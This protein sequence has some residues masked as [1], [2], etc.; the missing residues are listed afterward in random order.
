MTMEKKG[1]T[2]VPISGGDDKRSITATF[3]ITLDKTFL[4]MQFIYKGKTNPS[5]G[6]VNFLQKLSLSVNK[7]HYSNKKESSKLLKGIILLY[8]QNVHQILGS[9]L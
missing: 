5:L 1:T 9:E 4:Q 3:V 2:N 7:K 8:I 6:K